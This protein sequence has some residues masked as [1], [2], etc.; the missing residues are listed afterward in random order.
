[1][2]NALLLTASLLATAFAATGCAADADSDATVDEADIRA[3]KIVQAMDVSKLVSDSPGAATKDANSKNAWGIAFNPANGAAWVSNA[4][5]ST[6]TVYDKTG[7]LLLTVAMPA[8]AGPTGQMFNGSTNFKGDTFISVGESGKIM[9]WKSGTTAVVRAQMAGANYKGAALSAGKLYAANFKT[10][11]VDMYNSN[12]QLQACSGGFID[13]SIPAGFAPFNVWEY[14][15]YLFV[16]YAKQDAE[17]HDDARGPG[18]GF[19]NVFDGDGNV[20]QRLVSKDVLNSPWGMTI[21]EEQLGNL[22]K[23]TLLVG[24]FGDGKV[25]TFELSDAA[26]GGFTAKFAGKLGNASGKALVIDGL[27]GLATDPSKNIWFTAGPNGEAGG[28]VGIL[29]EHKAARSGG[30]Y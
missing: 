6:S 17:A 14:E 7:K 5:S 1:M 22:K 12:Y 8:D 9:G 18:N 25:N 23:E 10:G 28:L 13:N 29:R 30:G 19:I 3:N 20:K 27:W 16:S 4:G 26:G 2:R 21:V 11:R 24:N 15:G